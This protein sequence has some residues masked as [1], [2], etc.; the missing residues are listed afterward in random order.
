MQGAESAIQSPLC[1]QAHSPPYSLLCRESGVQQSQRQ[2]TYVER[3]LVHRRLGV[4]ARRL[5]REPSSPERRKGR[6]GAARFGRTFRGARPNCTESDS[7][8][9][10][11]CECRQVCFVACEES[12]RILSAYA[13]N[14]GGDFTFTD[15]NKATFRAQRQGVPVRIG[16]ACV[17]R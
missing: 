12:E 14:P 6:S 8:T 10:R 17:Q 7:D 2:N 16:L 11:R 15:A 5:R 4:G 9:L 1:N 3:S 13:I